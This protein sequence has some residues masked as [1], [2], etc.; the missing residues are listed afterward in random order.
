MVSKIPRRGHSRGGRCANLSQIAGQICT[1]LFQEGGFWQVCLEPFD[2]GK[3]TSAA[4]NL[5]LKKGTSTWQMYLYPARRGV[6]DKTA[7]FWHFDHRIK[8]VFFFSF[9]G[10]EKGT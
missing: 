7:L 6:K 3:G 10:Q 4:C 5:T 8:W 1:K 9:I 2:R